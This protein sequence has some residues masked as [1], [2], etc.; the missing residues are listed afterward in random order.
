LEGYKLNDF[1][2]ELNIEKE[3]ISVF[4]SGPSVNDIPDK[5]LNEIL[6]KTFSFTLNWGWKKI[7]SNVTAYQSKSIKAEIPPTI[8]S[9]DRHILECNLTEKVGFTLP[10]LLWHLQ[11]VS[12]KQILLFGLDGVAGSKYYDKYTKKDLHARH[13]RKQSNIDR[14]LKMLDVY[15]QKTRI[16]NCNLNSNYSGFI[17]KNWKDIIK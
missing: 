6:S 17:K 11:R 16:F 13:G 14:S 5:D 2:K 4:A 1:F 12:D 10:K 8:V 15:I 9:I 3:Y 7:N